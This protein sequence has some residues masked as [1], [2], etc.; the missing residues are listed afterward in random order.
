[1]LPISKDDCL[2]ITKGS[3]VKR[4]IGPTANRKASRHRP[5]VGA[6]LP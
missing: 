6:R 1:M 3:E 5:R 2:L 4:D